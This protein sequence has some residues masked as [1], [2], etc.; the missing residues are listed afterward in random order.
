[1][2]KIDFKKTLKHLYNPPG[3]KFTLV[4]VPPM[5]FLTIDTQGSVHLP[6]SCCTQKMYAS[7]L[8]V[9]KYFQ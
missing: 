4:D 7:S 3:G 1:M 6:E 5:N 8:M 2:D 9:L